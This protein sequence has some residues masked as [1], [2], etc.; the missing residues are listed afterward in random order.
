MAGLIKKY[1]DTLAGL[2]VSIALT[3]GIALAIAAVYF[4]LYL[5]METNHGETITVPNVEGMSMNELVDFL[6]DRNL[7]YEVSD[8]SYSIQFPPLT[9]L[10]Q[11]PPAGSKVK[12]GRKIF[13]SVNRIEPPTVPVPDLVGGSLLNADAVLR[14]NELK[15]GKIELVRGPFLHVVNQMTYQGKPIDAGTRIPKGSVISLVIQDGGSTDIPMPDVEGFTFE[16][17]QVA[18]LGSQLSIG[19]VHLVGD[20]TGVDPNVI[21]Q[22][23]PV[24]NKVLK[25]GD[26]VEVWIGKAGSEIPEDEVV[27]PDVD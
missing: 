10:K 2:L 11:Y 21:L 23:K 16:D 24:A 6:G 9:V 7:G 26:V 1:N 17:A 18:I 27:K 4:Y 19:K 22:T 20:T 13:I 8:S 15:R 3:L 25:V 14:S 12:E 5:P